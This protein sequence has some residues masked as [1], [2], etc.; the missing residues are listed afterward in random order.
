MKRLR[1]VV[2]PPPV[3]RKE[4]AV[5]VHVSWPG[6]YKYTPGRPTSTEHATRKKGPLQRRRRPSCSSALK[7]ALGDSKTHVSCVMVRISIPGFKRM[8]VWSLL[9]SRL[10]QVNLKLVGAPAPLHTPQLPFFFSGR[11]I[12][13]PLDCGEKKSGKS[14]HGHGMQS[15][16]KSK[17]WT[18][19][20]E[21]LSLRTA[22][23]VVTS[24]RPTEHVWPIN[25]GED[26]NGKPLSAFEALNVFIAEQRQRLAHKVLFFIVI[27]DSS[28]ATEEQS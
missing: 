14:K 4:Q 15:L 13:P 26:G 7:S 25:T 16:G 23:G 12:I 17:V 27:L 22:T 18:G 3:L 11:Q 1:R 9:A 10:N 21:R 24:S 2:W 20:S 5:R 8:W 6:L 28:T 19:R